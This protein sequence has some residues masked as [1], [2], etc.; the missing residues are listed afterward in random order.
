MRTVDG[1]AKESALLIFNRYGSQY[2]FAEAWVDGNNT[3]L[4][5]LRSRAERVAQREL[6]GIKPATD[7]VALKRR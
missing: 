3:G 6:A 2:F 7:T 4:Q 5:A 1:K